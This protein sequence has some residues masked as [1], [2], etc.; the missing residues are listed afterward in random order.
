MMPRPLNNAVLS[1]DTSIASFAS[2]LVF[3]KAQ[4]RFLS[5]RYDLEDLHTSS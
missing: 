5:L 2:R 3:C 4:K 1:F